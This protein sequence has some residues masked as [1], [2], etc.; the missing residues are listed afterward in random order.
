MLAQAVRTGIPDVHQVLHNFAACHPAAA[1]TQYFIVGSKLC[2]PYK[3][4]T[5]SSI[6]GQHCCCSRL[7]GEALRDAYAAVTVQ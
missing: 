6:V 3:T 7:A 1:P 4:H 5:S 2:A